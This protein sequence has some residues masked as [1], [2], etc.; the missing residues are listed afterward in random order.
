MQAQSSSK[1]FVLPF[2]KFHKSFLFPS[3]AC[4]S[5]LVTLFSFQGAF[6]RLLSKPDPNTQSLECL[7]LDSNF[8]S[9]GLSLGPIEDGTR[10]APRSKRFGAAKTLPQAEFI[11]AEDM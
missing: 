11:S 10:E 5:Y 3:V 7:N 9:A 1:L 4:S 6:F 8:P 2:E